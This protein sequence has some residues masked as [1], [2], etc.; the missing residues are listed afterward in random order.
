MSCEMKFIMN[1]K[2]GKMRRTLTSQGL[3]DADRWQRNADQE[4]KNWQAEKIFVNTQDEQIVHTLL[5]AVL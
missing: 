3:P 4:F 1:F 5:G 2:W